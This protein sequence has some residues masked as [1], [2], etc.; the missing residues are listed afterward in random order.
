MT[1]HWQLLTADSRNLPLSSFAVQCVVTSPPYWNLRDYSLEGAIG[2][3]ESLPE[4]IESLVATF[5]EVNR[6]L[7]NDGTVWLNLGDMY[8]G[9]NYRGGGI[10]TSSAKQVSNS[11]STDF[12]AKKPPRIPE[13]LKR[14]DL[15]GLPWRVAFALQADGWWLRNEII[16][17]KRNP[18]PESIRDRLT[19]SHETVFLFTKNERYYFDQQAIREPAS[20]AGREIS[21]GDRSFARRQADGMNRPRSG[22]AHADTYS[23][24]EFRNK[25]DVWTLSTEPN[26]EAHFATFP[27]KLVE[28]CVLAGSRE[29]DVVLDPFSGSGTT[30]LVALQ[31]GRSFIGVD[32]KDEYGQMARRRLGQVE[33]FPLDAR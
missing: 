20:E 4:Y 25:R 21:L 30:G 11:G 24:K 31:H 1:D 33:G 2:L 16:W 12:M 19:K 27:K 14:K 3:E 23:V 9:A 18:M 32:L 6:V 10:Q 17:A 15:I 13:G 22:N 28:P 5:R 26:P 8:A 29:G 7:K